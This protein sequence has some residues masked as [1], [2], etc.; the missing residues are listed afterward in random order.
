MKYFIYH[1]LHTEYT[2]FFLDS[3]TFCTI[4][5]ASK[6]FINELTVY[7]DGEEVENNITP[8]ILSTQGYN[9]ILVTISE[10]HIKTR[11]IL[12]DEILDLID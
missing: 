6:H 2:E 1:Q 10:N 3:K 5:E 7:L 4:K 12:P 8:E 11:S 9:Y